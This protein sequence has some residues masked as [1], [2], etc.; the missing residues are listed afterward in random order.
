MPTLTDNSTFVGEG[1]AGCCLQIAG[2]QEKGHVH[3]LEIRQDGVNGYLK[4][5]SLILD[6]C[7]TNYF[8]KERQKDRSPS[9]HSRLRNLFA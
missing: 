2:V 5:I 3:I 6:G 9:T 7:Q 8:D 1:S 4:T